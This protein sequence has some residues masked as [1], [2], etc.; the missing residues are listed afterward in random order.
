MLHL[1]INVL[2][3]GIKKF[4]DQLK[5]QYGKRILG[6]AEPHLSRIKGSYI[7]EILIKIEKEADILTRIK[8]DIMR[9]SQE[10]KNERAFSSIRIQIDVDP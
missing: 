9:L 2:D 7:R 3:E 5:K 8:M 10:L 6:P 4:A 1:K